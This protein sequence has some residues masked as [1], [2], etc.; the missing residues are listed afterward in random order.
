MRVLGRD[1][2]R[3]LTLHGITGDQADA[4][5]ELAR[6]A[7]VKDWWHQY[8]GAIPEWFQ[9]LS[10][11]RAAADGAPERGAAGTAAHPGCALAAGSECLSR[12]TRHG[13]TQVTLRRL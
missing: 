6:R 3:L 2:Q 9:I 8:S 12:S 1:V 11:G 13:P 10:Q 5:L 7:R 4:V